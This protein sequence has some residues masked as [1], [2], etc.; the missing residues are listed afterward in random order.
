MIESLL[1]LFEQLGYTGILLLMLLESTVFPVP[2]ELVMIPAGVLAAQGRMDP[3]VAVFMGIVGSL[4]GAMINYWVGFKLGKPVLDKYGKYVLLPPHR[5]ARVEKF[6][7]KHGEISTFTGRL[8]LGVRH[9]ISIPAGLAH[10]NLTRFVGFTVLGSGIW[11]SV[12][13]ALGYFAGRE[14]D[15]VTDAEIKALW[16]RYSTPITIGL[17]LFC[18]VVIAA[19]IFWHRHRRRADSEV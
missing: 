16:G 15:Q 5:M 12:L 9:L 4:L 7:L 10:M 17:I 14:L 6:F 2:S 18:L 19:Y 11:V 8:L 13:V 1:A 3:F